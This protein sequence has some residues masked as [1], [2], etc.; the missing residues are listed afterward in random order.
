M[1]EEHD[2]AAYGR[3][4][5]QAYDDFYDALGVDTEGAVAFLAELAAG[6]AVLEFGIG[7]GRLALPLAARGLTVHGVDAS[8]E[9]LAHLQAKPGGEDI[10]VTIGDFAQVQV[11]GEFT[12]VVL[13]LNTIYALPT[14]EAQL[15]C[16]INA[17]T[18]LRTGGYFVLEAWVPTHIITDS[19]R[20]L[21]VTEEQILLEISE[22][23][24]ATQRMRTA[25]LQLRDGEVH[26]YPANHRYAWPAELD[27]MGRLAGLRLIERWGGWRRQSF[28]SDSRNYISVYQTHNP[29]RD[30]T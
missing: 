4:M 14:Q 17:A 3:H 20:V 21:L 16:F 11:P 7:T 1:M 22:A 29:A 18:H 6:G 25:K 12:L 26:L 10:P 27:L 5:A 19:I 23:D 9:M 30:T 28:S 24:T 2:P 15:E 13:A 8:R